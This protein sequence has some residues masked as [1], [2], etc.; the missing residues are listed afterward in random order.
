MANRRQGF[1]VYTR[2][3]GKHKPGKNGTSYGVVGLD[4]NVYIDPRQPPS[5]FLDTLIHEVLHIACPHMSEEN[6]RRVSWTISAA[7][8]KKGYRRQK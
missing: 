8:W 4:G 3:L 1:K 5:E 6:V 7:V 2:R